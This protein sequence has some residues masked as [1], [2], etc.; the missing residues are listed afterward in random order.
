MITV[1]YTRVNSCWPGFGPGAKLIIHMTFL[2]QKKQIHEYEVWLKQTACVCYVSE[3]KTSYTSLY[4]LHMY[5]V[6]RKYPRKKNKTCGHRYVSC[7]RGTTWGSYMETVFKPNE[8]NMVIFPA[9]HDNVWSITQVFWFLKRSEISMYG[10][11]EKDRQS[12]RPSIMKTKGVAYEYFKWQPHNSKM[13]WE[14]EYM[15]VNTAVVPYA[16]EAKTRSRGTVDQ[17]YVHVVD[18]AWT[19][20]WAVHERREQIEIK[21]DRPQMRDRSLRWRGK[22]VQTIDKAGWTDTLCTTK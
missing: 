22:V 6:Y 19:K 13:I 18:P 15:C 17:K 11:Q 1:I 5:Q 10:F 12:I 8:I 20:N 16:S 4:M 14:W 7:H 3:E 21:T 9:P 2:G